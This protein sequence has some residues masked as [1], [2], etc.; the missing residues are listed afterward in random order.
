MNCRNNRLE[1]IRGIVDAILRKQ[2]DPETSRCGFVHLYGVSAVC[3]L[4]AERRGLDCEICALAGMLHD[5]AS[6]ETGNSHNHAQRSAIRA[7]DLLTEAGAFTSDE[8]ALITDAIARHSNKDDIDNPMAE[9]L[10][11]ADIF[12]HYLYNPELEKNW[13]NRPRNQRLFAEFGLINICGE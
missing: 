3:V 8:I 4:L 5:I 6:Y 13:N 2:V 1:H 7:A 9:L 10:K 11:D 12:Q